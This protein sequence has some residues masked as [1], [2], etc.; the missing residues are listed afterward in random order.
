MSERQLRAA[1]RRGTPQ[2]ARSVVREL[3]RQHP[4]LVTAEGG[5]SEWLLVWDAQIAPQIIRS[6]ARFTL[7][8]LFVD[9]DGVPAL[10]VA[11]RSTDTRVRRE[12]IGRVLDLAANGVQG[13][14]AAQLR[15]AL[16]ATQGDAIRAVAAWQPDTN[17]DLDD[18]L[19]RVGDNLQQGRLR[20][21]LATDVVPDEM[22]RLVSFLDDQLDRTRL[23][24][25]ELSRPALTYGETAVP[26]R[27]Q[28][29][30]SKRVAHSGAPAT[31]RSRDDM[32]SEATPETRT[33]LDR[34][35]TLAHDLNL[36]TEHS[37]S[38]LLLKTGARE[39]LAAVYFPWNTIDIPLQRLR[40]KGWSEQAERI[41][42]AL[43]S[44]TTKRLPARSPAVPTADALN[45]WP[46]VREALTTM[47]GLYAA[48]SESPLHGA[49]A[50]LV[51]FDPLSN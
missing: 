40:D 11:A 48:G 6:P 36:I 47:A 28:R 12:A 44:T 20:L 26:A 3:A 1:G 49:A 7:D 38:A 30:S 34:I 41:H 9:A 27:V 10:V 21:I 8:Y 25:L 31:R 19:A 29:P 43:Q 42:Y 50:R 15:E 51:S 46:L 16:T 5:P 22:R 14:S 39:T 2:S 23:Y 35:E 13:W 17:L 4:D 32:L 37:P 18:F 45:N 24:A 33:V